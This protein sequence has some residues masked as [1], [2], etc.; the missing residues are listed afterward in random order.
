[1]QQNPLFPSPEV[2]HSLLKRAMPRLPA[3]QAFD[4]VRMSAVPG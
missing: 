2:V 1:M 4:S 3:T